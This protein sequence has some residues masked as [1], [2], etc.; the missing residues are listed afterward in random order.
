MDS[1]NGLKKLN[2]SVRYISFKQNPPFV[3][4]HVLRK[5]SSTFF[6]F[7][8]HSYVFADWF[9]KGIFKSPLSLHM[10]ELAGN[11]VMLQR[12]LFSDWHFVKRS[13]DKVHKPVCGHAV[14][15]HVRYVL[16]CINICSWE[17]HHSL[18]TGL[19]S[20]THCKVDC[21]Q[22]S[23]RCVSRSAFSELLINYLPLSIF[24]FI[25]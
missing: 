9:L 24:F 25:V 17:V 14:F 8:H 22:P 1:L 18:N 7:E 13:V 6:D 4:V 2:W 20:R 11:M 19:T 21:T 5:T 3:H 15:S 12:C 16:T 10:Y 23:N